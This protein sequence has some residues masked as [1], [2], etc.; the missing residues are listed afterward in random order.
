MT[1]TVALGTST[2][3]SMTV[4]ET[5]ICVSFLRKLSMTAS[6]SSL[7]RRP[8]RRPSF[9]LGKTSLE[10]R[11]YSSIAALSSSFDSSITG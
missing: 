2:P 7:E 6:F 5:R 10:R 11:L 4:V 1:M 8:W 3:T 9:S